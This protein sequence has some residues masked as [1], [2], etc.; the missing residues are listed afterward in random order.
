M[1]TPSRGMREGVSLRAMPLLEASPAEGAAVFR[2]R[3]QLL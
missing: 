2:Q 3:E 1:E